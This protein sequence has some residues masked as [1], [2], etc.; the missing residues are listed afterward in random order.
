MR[1]HA[2]AGPRP[3]PHQPR[4]RVFPLVFPRAEG[5]RAAAS[6]CTPAGA[7]LLLLLLL[8]L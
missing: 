6:V 1:L 8:G 7:V 5:R 3:F 4:P 2:A